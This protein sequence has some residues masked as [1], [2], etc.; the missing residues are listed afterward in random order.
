MGRTQK[1]FNLPFK[2]NGEPIIFVPKS[3]LSSSDRFSNSRIYSEY[4]LSDDKNNFN[5]NDLP[6]DRDP[7]KV[8]YDDW[9]GGISYGWGSCWDDDYYDSRFNTGNYSGKKENI[10][11]LAN[12]QAKNL[13][14]T[15]AYGSLQSKPE[16]KRNYIHD[17]T[18]N[19]VSYIDINH[20][21]TKIVAVDLHEKRVAYEK[22]K[23]EAL[24]TS[25][26]VHYSRIE[27]DGFNLSVF[28]T[29]KNGGHKTKC[30]RN[31]IVEYLPDLDFK[32]LD[33]LE[34]YDVYIESELLY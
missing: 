28:Y 21:T 10:A 19:Y 32:D 26:E 14:K 5:W 17:K 11:A 23:I 9:Y 4:I 18:F 33:V 13:D 31:D 12:Y 22:R 6:V 2:P 29:T 34:D 24:L 27:W 1:V 15:Y 3:F 30:D 8:E 7:S 16:I 20:T 25:L